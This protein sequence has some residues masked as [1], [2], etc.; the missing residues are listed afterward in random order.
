MLLIKTVRS[1]IWIY[2]NFIS[3]KFVTDCASM[4]L[5]NVYNK[6]WCI[7]SANVTLQICQ[8]SRHISYMH[9]AHKYHPWCPELL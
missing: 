8:E 7:Q 1:V 3:C 9:G 4:M 2:I 5:N 6:S